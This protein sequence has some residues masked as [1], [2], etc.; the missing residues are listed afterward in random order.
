MLL[1]LPAVAHYGI[2]SGK[3]LPFIKPRAVAN[4]PNNYTPSRVSCPAKR[5]V[6]CQAT[7]LSIKET[8]WLELR[9]NNIISALKGVLNRVNGGGIDI[10]AYVNGIV[11]NGSALPR[12]DIAISGVGYRSMLNGT[13][14]IAAFDNRTTSST[15]K[16]HLGGILQAATYLSGLS[17]GSWVCGKPLR[18]EFYKC[19]VHHLHIQ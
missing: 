1:A 19:R 5:P 10:D 12:I 13:G 2:T 14:A 6:I 9:D 18:A 15:D 3:Y 16:G 11:S 7:T 4:A 17:G 8:A